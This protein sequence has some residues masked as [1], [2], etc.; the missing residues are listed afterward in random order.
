MDRLRVLIAEDHEELRATIVDLLHSEF[1][2]V[3]A[4]ADGQ[5]LVEAAPALNPSL[6]VSDIDMPLMDGFSAMRALRAKSIQTPFVFITLMSLDGISSGVEDHPVGFVHKAD[7]AN[8]LKSALHAVA[9]GVS[10]LSRSF[11]QNHEYH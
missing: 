6:I 7:L 1:T 4:V 11:R 8:E 3:G 2:V 5:Q 9:V 10:Y